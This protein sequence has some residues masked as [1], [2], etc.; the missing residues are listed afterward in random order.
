MKCPKCG[1]KEVEYDTPNKPHYL[2]CE[3]ECGFEFCYDEYREE[4]Y[5]MN[6]NVLPELELRKEEMKK[7]E[8]RDGSSDL[9]IA[10]V[11]GYN[12]AI[13]DYEAF[14]PSEEEIKSLVIANTLKR[15]IESDKN[16]AL[17]FKCCGNIGKAIENR[18]LC[19]H[20]NK[21][22]TEVINLWKYKLIK[23][24]SKRLRGE[25]KLTIESMEKI[26]AEMREEK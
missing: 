7:P 1:S 13:D 16:Q 23:I 26:D 6:G 24:I 8:K 4:A 14:L 5:D 17:V 10:R 15:N 12:L 22:V 11:E 21:E 3:C 9:N 25:K 19:P 2:H 18:G 20:C